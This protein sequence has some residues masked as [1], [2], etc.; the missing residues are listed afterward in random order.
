[1]AFSITVEPFS[2]S[3]SNGVPSKAMR[4]I[5]V[6]GAVPEAMVE[7]DGR[8]GRKVLAKRVPAEITTPCGKSTA[9]E[10]HARAT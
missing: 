6:I 8:N 7:A 9:P 4:V 3:S 1:M 10:R 5:L 2:A